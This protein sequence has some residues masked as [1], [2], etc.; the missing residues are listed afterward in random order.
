MVFDL[1]TTPPHGVVDAAA[2]DDVAVDDV[3]CVKIE[4]GK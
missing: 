4:S 2:V 3:V 1:Y